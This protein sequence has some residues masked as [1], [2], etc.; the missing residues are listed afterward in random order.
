MRPPP[1]TILSA[2]L[3]RRATKDIT[4]ADFVLLSFFYQWCATQIDSPRFGIRYGSK[5]NTV[6]NGGGKVTFDLGL[7]TVGV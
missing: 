3:A 4:D 2:L 5:F 7:G 6:A 1:D